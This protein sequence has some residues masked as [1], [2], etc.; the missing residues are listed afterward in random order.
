MIPVV[1]V[2]M[3]EAEGKEERTQLV[4]KVSEGLVLLEEAYVHCDKEK[5]SS[6]KTGSVTSILFLDPAWDGKG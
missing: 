5:I 2:V 1:K 6:E 3:R 4:Q